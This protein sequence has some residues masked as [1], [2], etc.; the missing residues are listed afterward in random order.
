[1]EI[2]R[3]QATH[4]RCF[5]RLDLKPG[6]RLNFLTGPNG[7]G[8]T[9]VLEAIYLLSHGRS[10]R[11]GAPDVLAQRGQ[12]GF[13]V[14]AEVASKSYGCSALGV[15]RRAEGWR[16]HVNGLDQRT[17][18]PVLERCAVGCFEPG[19]ASLIAGGAEERR[20]F[21]DWGVFHVK[22]SSLEFWRNWKRA[23]RQRN[24]LLRS[25]GS[26]EQ[27][28]IWETELERF[29]HP[30]ESA[31]RIYFQSLSPHL[32]RFFGRLL[33]ELGPPRLHYRPGWNIEQPLSQVLKEQR[34]H[35]G[36]LGHTRSGPHRADWRVGFEHAPNRDYLSRGQTKLAA[37]ACILAQASLF[38]ADTGE[39]PILCLDDPSSEL[40]PNHQQVVLEEISSHPLQAWVTGTQATRLPSLPATKLFHVEQKAV[41]TG[42]V[43]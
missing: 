13:S 38:A 37:L 15:E 16:L 10:F 41:R 7:A 43:V 32:E 19:S 34:L 28:L 8:K 26:P 2:Q 23:L 31:R 9:T 4:L 14:H 27:F 30:I 39:W 12:A 29:A 22:H 1:M 25:G 20:R 33:P 3:L 6:P 42:R 5:D 36:H 21:L 11:G 17:L 24:A 40:D 35:D 18:A